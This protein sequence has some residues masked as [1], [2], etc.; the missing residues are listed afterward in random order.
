MTWHY[1]F[2]KTNPRLLQYQRLTAHPDAATVEDQSQVPPRYGVEINSN[3][4]NPDWKIDRAARHDVEERAQKDFVTA[5]PL[6]RQLDRD[7][8]MRPRDTGLREAEHARRV[9]PAAGPAESTTAPDGF[10]KGIAAVSA[11]AERPN[12]PDS[13]RACFWRS[14][15]KCRRSP[16]QTRSLER[17]RVK[18]GT[19]SVA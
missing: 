13:G 16:F 3:R 19:S 12:L 1:I 7:G 4:N 10:P 15:K 17:S 6:H 9:H 8:G 11:R 18:P 5:T 14:P 2:G